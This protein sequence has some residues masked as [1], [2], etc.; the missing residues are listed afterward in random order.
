MSH[1]H[2]PKRAATVLAEQSFGLGLRVW[3]IAS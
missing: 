2:C 1:R 3:F